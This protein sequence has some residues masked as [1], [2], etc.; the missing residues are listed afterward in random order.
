RAG[1]RGSRRRSRP[2]PRTSSRPVAVRWSR[3]RCGSSRDPSYAPSSG[4]GLAL[5]ALAAAGAPRL[6]DAAPG[7]AGAAGFP[8]AAP[9][10][11][12]VPFSP[13]ALAARLSPAVL[14]ARL[15]LL[16]GAPAP[17]PSGSPVAERPAA[18]LTRA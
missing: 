15:G 14:A 6:A 12:R 11:A 2:G 1:G 4:S 16:A 18:A 5:E 13:A 17:A 8:P 3:V 9:L 10:A 7:L